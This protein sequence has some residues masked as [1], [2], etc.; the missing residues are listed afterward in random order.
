MS[1][2]MLVHIR[3]LINTWQINNKRRKEE[4]NN[5]PRK[6][7]K[8]KR[9]NLTKYSPQSI[10]LDV[11]TAIHIIR[12]YSKLFLIKYIYKFQK[13][14]LITWQK[15]VLIVFIRCSV[16]TIQIVMIMVIT[17]ITISNIQEIS[18]CQILF[19]VHCT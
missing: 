15:R 13:S 11:I 2:L 1:A 19:N 6:T 8:N 9:V 16:P 14:C 12:K 4:R 7:I 18:L 10:V 5:E 17:I 3:K